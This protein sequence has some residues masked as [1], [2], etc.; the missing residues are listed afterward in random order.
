MANGSFAGMSVPMKNSPGW[1]K[2]CRRRYLPAIRNLKYN[3]ISCRKYS[4]GKGWTSL[5]YTGIGFK[6]KLL[7]LQCLIWPIITVYFTLPYIKLKLR[8]KDCI[9]AL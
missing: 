8:K 9:Q 5:Y 2:P 7:R 6:N 4:E 1:N 3:A